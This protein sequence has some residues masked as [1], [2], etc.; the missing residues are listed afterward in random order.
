MT[1]IIRVQVDN[2]NQGQI[3]MTLFYE[4]NFGRFTPPSYFLGYV[5]LCNM[6][7][8]AWLFHSMLLP[9]LHA[10]WPKFRN[11]SVVLDGWCNVEIIFFFLG[12]PARKLHIPPWEKD[13][14]LQ[15]YLGWGYVSSQE[16]PHGISK[17][18]LDLD[19]PWFS[20]NRSI[21]ISF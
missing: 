18:F 21:H 17:T 1:H 2:L 13:M 19:F 15:T 9:T 12:Y 4:G 7:Q 20:A 5:R 10:E 6:N 11:A 8:S 16:G 3:F 14:Y